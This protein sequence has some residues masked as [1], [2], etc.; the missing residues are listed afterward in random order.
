[1]NATIDRLNTAL[2][3]RYR[4]ER[5]LAKGGMGTVYAAVDL[6]HGRP[7]A[8]KVLHGDLASA[9]ASAGFLREI[10]ITARLRHPCVLPL[11]DSGEKDGFLYYVM[12]LIEGESL[13]DRLEREGVLPVDDALQIAGRVAEALDYAHG[14]DVVHRDVKPENILL[15]GE[16]VYIADFG[17]ARA[18]SDAGGARV[19][20]T[21]HS[22]GTP[23]YMSPEQ[24]SGDKRIDGRA[25]IY[26][27][28]C[29]LY[30]M[31]TGE[32]PFP[33]RT[34][35]AVVVRHLTETPSPVELLRPTVTVSLSRAVAGA[36]AKLPADRPATATEFIEACKA[37]DPAPTWRD[38]VGPVATWLAAAAA[39]AVAV[40]GVRWLWV[41]EPTLDA[42]KVVVFPLVP[43]A[44]VED[45]AAGW[46]V[47]LAIGAALEH[48]EP[49]K[50]IDAW[51]WLPVSGREDPAT[52]TAAAANGLARERGARYLIGGAI[53]ADA[54]ATTVVL[55]LQDVAGDSLVT[56]ES[57]TG[58]A[59]TPLAD[60][61]LEAVVPVLAQ[62]IDPGRPVDLTPLTDRAAGAVALS[63]Q[64]D[65]QYRRSQFGSAQGFYERAVEADSSLAFAAVKGAQAA[66]WN[67]DF[68]DAASLIALARRHGDVL[69]RKYRRFADG[70]KAYLEGAADSA[71]SAFEG[72]LA[73]DPEW[74]EAWAALGEVYQHLIPSTAPGD[75]LATAA[76][77]RAAAL[78]SAFA[79]PLVHLA[80]GRTRRGELQAAASLLARLRSMDADTMLVRE[81]DLMLSCRN[82]S[83]EDFPWPE[84]VERTPQ[85]TLMAALALDPADPDG[86]A[87]GALAAVIAADLPIAY[88]WTAMRAL[89]GIL[90]ARGQSAGADSLLESFLDQGIAGTHAVF[91]IDALAGAP[92]EE[93]AARAVQRAREGSSS[94]AFGDL[95]A[96][97]RWLLA[98]WL[99]RQGDVDEVAAIEGSLAAH[100]DSVDLPSAHL[101]ADA[102]RAHSD[103]ARGDTATALVRLSSLT[104]NA[105]RNLLEFGDFEPLP[106]ERMLLAELLLARGEYEAAYRVARVFDHPA[107]I[108]YGPFLPRSLAIRLAAATALGDSDRVESMR[109]RLGALGWEEP[110]PTSP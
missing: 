34:A 96:E 104:P 94:P 86:C 74:V 37:P 99:A 24:G 65:R 8:I 59:G 35:R 25:D 50:W 70:L 75:S 30:E 47:A 68:G 60:I 5:E 77:Q 69:P 53:R 66:S 3:D 38:R 100:A 84:W 7:V 64:G 107:P 9:V 10:R 110:P 18:L 83:G 80:E 58:P 49:L 26:S 61:A 56:Q 93:Q 12:P 39:L 88:R 82:E 43:G 46:D 91:I 22:V 33:G 40:L 16:H 1:M 73:T 89:Q 79:P 109:A 87:R 63:I 13:A 81:V 78:D 20:A 29:V 36:L 90:L 102:V 6:A 72:A 92:F 27:L 21:G 98:A 51:T 17:V 108:V 97:N 44:G 4:V 23:A 55:R 71:V 105:P 106:I 54:G 67:S 95:P 14:Q 19:T 52:V 103:L 11:L 76:F 41:G 62:L 45:R 31:L 85:A 2:P 48:T 28:A 32:P 101:M 42:N 15:E 57:A